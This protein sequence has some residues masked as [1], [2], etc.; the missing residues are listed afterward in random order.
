LLADYKRIEDIRGECDTLHKKSIIARLRGDHSLAEE[1][2]GRYITLYSSHMKALKD[3]G[4]LLD[5]AN[6]ELA[7]PF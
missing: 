4:D 5:G 7:D 6:T 1:W 3:D 2:A